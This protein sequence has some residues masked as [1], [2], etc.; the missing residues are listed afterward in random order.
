MKVYHSTDTSK[1][2]KLP[3][4]KDRQKENVQESSESR[5]TR[6]RRRCKVDWVD[7]MKK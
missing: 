2:P 1:W 6:Q 3:V 4:S 7:V 5:H